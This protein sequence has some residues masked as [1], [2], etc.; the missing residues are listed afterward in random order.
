MKEKSREEVR[1]RMVRVREN[2]IQ[3]MKEE[4]RGEKIILVM[5]L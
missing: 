2:K 1:L 4:E 5:S 3:Q